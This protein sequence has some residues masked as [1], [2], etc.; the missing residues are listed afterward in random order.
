MGLFDFMKPI[1]EL[2]EEDRKW[3]KMWNLW[4]EGEAD[5]PYAELMEYDAEVNNGGHSQYFF[6]VENCGDLATSV[7]TLLKVLPEALREN[8]RCAYDM[9]CSEKGDSE[10][11]EEQYEACDN[12]FWQQEEQLLEI[13][14]GYATTMVL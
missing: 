7:Q 12:V 9:Y 5:S 14:K 3:N 8:L 1:Q 4:A 6:N 2:P 10:E 11:A 13:L